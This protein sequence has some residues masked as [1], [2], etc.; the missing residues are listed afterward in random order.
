MRQRRLVWAV[1]GSLSA[2]LLFVSPASAATL[3]DALSWAYANNPQLNAARAQL[4]ATDEDVPRARSGYRPSIFANADAGIDYTD[5]SNGG[6]STTYP[7]GLGVTVEQPI[8]LGFRTK[9][10][11]RAA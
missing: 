9:N 7:R 8:F 2:A 11:V 6:S 4:R 3:V 10:S 1:A 5:S